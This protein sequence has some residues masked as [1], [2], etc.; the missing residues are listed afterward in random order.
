M[1][2]ASTSVYS[3]LMENFHSIKF[4]QAE[5]SKLDWCHVWAHLSNVCLQQEPYREQ[6]AE[7][8]ATGLVTE[9]QPAEVL[10]MN[11]KSPL[12][13]TSKSTRIWQ[14]LRKGNLDKNEI[15]SQKHS[16]KKGNVHKT[17]CRYRR[18]IFQQLSTVLLTA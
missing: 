15:Q 3:V 14:P 9:C 6:A 13:P 10:D 2:I 1:G 11:K 7:Q 8:E 16:P 5:Q 18:N 4:A 12:K 17:L